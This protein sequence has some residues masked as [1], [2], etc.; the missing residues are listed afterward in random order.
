MEIQQLTLIVTEGDLT[1]V[2]RKHLGEKHALENVVCK[3]VPDGVQITG[4]V[5][6]FMPVSF[7]TLWEL[8]ILDGA[9]A[10]R[11]K[12]LKALGLPFNT[13]QGMFMTLLKDLA[14]KENWPEFRDDVVLLNMETLAAK[15]GV[16]LKGNFRGI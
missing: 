1:S 6:L 13:F 8:A 5:T 9:V 11:L 16:Q 10:A 14:K 12:K 4:E 3:I 2:A 7:D 15:E